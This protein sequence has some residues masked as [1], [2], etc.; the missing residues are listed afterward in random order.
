MKPH[1]PPMRKEAELHLAA[2]KEAFAKDFDAK[3]R[4]G[5]WEH[6]QTL[7]YQQPCW[8]EILS[9]IQD[10]VA[11]AYTLKIQL[12]AVADLALAG[13]EDES[14]CASLARENCRKILSI[15]Q[16]LPKISDSL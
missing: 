2:I 9:E 3:F 10:M 16:G 6:G 11:Y 14:L 13:C 1:V 7:L 15:L 4:K 8:V 5:Y 12:S